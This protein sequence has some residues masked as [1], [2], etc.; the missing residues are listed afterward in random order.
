MQTQQISVTL[1]ASHSDA[2][3]A[4]RLAHE[5]ELAASEAEKC[6]EAV[7]DLVQ[8][9]GAEGIIL[10]LQALDA[11]TQHLIELARLLGR[12]SDKA[13]AQELQTLLHDIKLSDMKHRL[14]GLGAPAARVDGELEL[15]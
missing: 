13:Q 6:Q 8:H 7:S 5:L 10:R 1:D 3:F 4:L 2:K 9:G 12:M 11:L 15:W 14:S